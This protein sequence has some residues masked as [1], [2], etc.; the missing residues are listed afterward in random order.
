MVVAHD[1]PAAGIVA[2]EPVKAASRRTS[3]SSVSYSHLFPGYEGVARAQRTAAE[4]KPSF[5]EV[6]GQLGPPVAPGGEI[7]LEV[8]GV[9]VRVRGQVETEALSRVLAALEVRR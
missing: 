7:E 5:V 1:V 9:R 4:N 8:G 6:T 3:R 2:A